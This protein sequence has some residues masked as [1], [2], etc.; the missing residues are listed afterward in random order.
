MTL[1]PRTH[2]TW[3]LAALSASMLFGQQAAY[4]AEPPKLT[5]MMAQELK[6]APSVL[7]NVEKELKVPDAWIAGAQ[8]EGKLS[9]Y[10]TFDLQEWP[11]IVAPFHAR[12]PFIKVSFVRS[13]HFNRVVKPLIAFNEGRAITDVI[14]A[15][16]GQ[17]RHYRSSNAL[18][19]LRELPTFAAVPDSM[20]DT[21]GLWVSDRVKYWCMAYNTKQV[22]KADLPKTWDDLL[23]NP[24]WHGRK[25]GLANR[26][27]NWLLAL[28]HHKGE[29]WAEDYTARL[30]R[31]TAPQLRKEGARAMVSLTVAGEFNMAIPA[32][33]YVVGRFAD[34]GAPVAWHCPDPATATISELAILKNSPHPNAAKIFVNWI[35]SKEGQIT[36]YYVSKGSPV[37]KDLLDKG[38]V[39][40]AEELKGKQIAVRT[41]DL[42]ESVYPKVLKTWNAQWIG[43]GG[44]VMDSKKV[45]KKVNVK[46]S[47]V[48]RGGR[49]LYFDVKGAEH[50]V[51]LSKSRSKVVI[52]GKNSVRGKLRAGMECA[53]TYPGNDGEAKLVTCK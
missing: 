29:A 48:G 19:D 43:S 2:L 23:S 37:H 10:G 31:N 40:Y 21:D 35:L 17:V 28:W 22:K 39:R 51:K 20:R 53:V 45:M 42:L 47:K 13:S 30:F 25:I 46:L 16:G 11:K 49:Q 18:V 24:A 38:L 8:K 7:D 5:Q 4:A 50:K 27:N 26:P 34:K 41:P 1:T 9:Y 32:T 15:I 44:P 3:V 52:G 6:L 33:S 14:A 12:Y 36:Q